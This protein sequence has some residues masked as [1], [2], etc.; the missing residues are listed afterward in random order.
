MD[1][2]FIIRK[3]II[4][5]APAVHNILLKA[6]EGYKTA[7]GIPGPLDALAESIKSIE[8]DIAGKDV[9]I[10]FMDNAPVGTV[11]IGA[12]DP[13]T[14]ILSRLGVVPGHQNIG[15]G[16]SLMNMVDKLAIE[17]CFKRVVLY[18]ASKN[19]DL[20]RFYYSRGFFVDSTSKARGYVRA[21]LV[22]EYTI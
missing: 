18:T 6:F 17:K 21:M 8:E 16:K 15:I 20:I 19:F 5:D 7:S 14:A 12:V 2:S 10:A 9:L 13:E 22:K 3:A 1:Y 4:E 11:R